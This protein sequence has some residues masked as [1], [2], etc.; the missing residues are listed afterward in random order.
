M[1]NTKDGCSRYWRVVSGDTCQGIA[2]GCGISLGTFYSWN[3]YVD[4]NTRIS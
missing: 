4:S 3:P 1:P 2:N